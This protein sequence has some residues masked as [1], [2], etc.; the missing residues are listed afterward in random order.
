M[1]DLV[2]IKE[3]HLQNVKAI[4]LL[5]IVDIPADGLII[6]SGENSAGKS[7]ILE[8]VVD[9]LQV[10]FPKASV[11]RKHIQYGKPSCD[12][13]IVFYNGVE[14]YV[15]LD[16]VSP[17]ASFYR[18]K[19]GDKE[20]KFTVNDSVLK[21]IM[22]SI[23]NVH[24]SEHCLNVHNTINA[25]YLCVNM[26]EA[27][28]YRALEDSIADPT[29]E[30]ALSFIESYTKKYKEDLSAVKNQIVGEQ[31]VL[32][33]AIDDDIDVL[34]DVLEKLKTLQR[35][36]EILDNKVSVY[37]KV[38]LK[39]EVDPNLIKLTLSSNISVEGIK[40]ITNYGELRYNSKLL[41][42]LRVKVCAYEKQSIY[43]GSKSISD[44]IK[45]VSEPIRIDMA[46]TIQEINELRVL[47]Q[48]IEKI[49]SAECPLCGRG[50]IE[51]EKGISDTRHTSCQEGLQHNIKL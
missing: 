7:T 16:R 46:R 51:D 13:R 33:R 12:G 26:T 44:L 30:S 27:Q 22:K 35:V 4:N 38:D 15:H 9:T 14:I 18:L 17:S 42:M 45:L 40:K 3:I 28:S 2:R 25:H 23:I 24:D 48:E 10:N 37:G 5:S 41:E 20:S 1:S 31:R 6:F 47:A 11:R 8:F 29:V 19:I 43:S 49:R 21:V 34:R 32:D 36:S 50:L 39:K